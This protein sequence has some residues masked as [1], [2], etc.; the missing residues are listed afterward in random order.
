[1][2]VKFR[3]LEQKLALP[4]HKSEVTFTQRSP[5]RL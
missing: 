5:N 4:S 2:N 1:M 3:S